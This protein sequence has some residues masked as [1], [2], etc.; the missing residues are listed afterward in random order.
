MRGSPY[1]RVPEYGENDN[2]ETGLHEDIQRESGVNK[3]PECDRHV[4]TRVKE[5]VCKDCG[6]IIKELRLN[7]GRSGERT[8]RTSAS[9]RA[10][11]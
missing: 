11:R 4:T 2:Y 8:M 9:E 1:W 10:H 6:L 5:T 7:Q 3:C